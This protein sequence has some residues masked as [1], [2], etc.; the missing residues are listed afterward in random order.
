MDLGS[1]ADEAREFAASPPC[2]CFG[3]VVRPAGIAPASRPWQ[4]RV[5]AV[6]PWSQNWHSAPVLPRAR[7]VLETGLRELAR[8]MWKVVAPAGFAP[9]AFSL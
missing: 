4:S 3:K 9:A 2:K 5:L 1:P 7:L 8:A 6:G